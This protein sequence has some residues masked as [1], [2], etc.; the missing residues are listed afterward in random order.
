MLQQSFT[1]LER[2]VL[3]LLLPDPVIIHQRLGEDLEV[4][5]LIPL[6]LRLLSLDEVRDRQHVLAD[7]V[8]REGLAHTADE[9]VRV[10]VAL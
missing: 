1:G 7:A 4:K 9:V 6:P 5:A 3:L 8:V 2:P 10:G